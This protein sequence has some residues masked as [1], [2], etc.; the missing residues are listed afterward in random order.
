MA[1][2]FA[3]ANRHLPGLPLIAMGGALNLA[4]IVANGGVMPA[5]AAALRLAGLPAEA[6]FSN[7]AHVADANLAWLGDV[8]AIPS[9]WPFANVFSIGD[10]VVV[11]G[12][13]YLTH[14][15]CRTLAGGADDTGVGTSTKESAAAC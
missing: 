9:G 2:W 1:G 13:G 10:V 4:A 8:F 11:I 15:W 12:L 3:L 5:S 14:R 7:S 6:G